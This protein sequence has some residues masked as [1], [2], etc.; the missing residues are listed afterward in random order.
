MLW[1]L[2]PLVPLA[3][4]G[5]DGQTSVASQFVG[6]FVNGSYSIHLW[7]PTKRRQLTLGFTTL[8]GSADLASDTVL[9][10]T[11]DALLVERGRC[12]ALSCQ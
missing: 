12:A 7:L 6:W 10:A 11:N 9:V 5:I 1:P 3:A 8:P 4:A 2:W